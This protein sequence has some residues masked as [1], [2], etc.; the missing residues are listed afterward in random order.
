MRVNFHAP[1]PALALCLCWV[2]AFGAGALQAASPTLL[3]LDRTPEL[4]HQMTVRFS[5]AI[6]TNASTNA[7]AFQVVNMESGERV[8][9][10]RAGP[11]IQRDRSVLTLTLESAPAFE[12]RHELRLVTSPGPEGWD[13]SVLL[14]PVGILDTTLPFDA[15]WRFLDDGLHVAAHRFYDSAWA[16]P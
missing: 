9:V 4:P 15:F 13:G 14:A 1:G 3:R 11:L 10:L 16:Q 5:T 8:R 7:S 6:S 2:A 12:E